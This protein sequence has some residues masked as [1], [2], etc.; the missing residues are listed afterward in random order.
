M[1]EN[2]GGS[3]ASAAIAVII[4]LAVFAFYFSFWEEAATSIKTSISS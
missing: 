3:L 2:S 1:V 4:L